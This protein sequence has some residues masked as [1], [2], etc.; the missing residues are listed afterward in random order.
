MLK[1]AKLE[2]YFRIVSSVSEAE[3]IIF[4]NEIQREMLGEDRHE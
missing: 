1:T 4:G 3:D 2:N